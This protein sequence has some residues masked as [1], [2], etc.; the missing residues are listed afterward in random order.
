MIDLWSPT[1]QTTFLVLPSWFESMTISLGNSKR[2]TIT[3]KGGIRNS[4]FFVQSLKVNGKPWN[5]GWV[6]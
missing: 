4:A 1:G 6:T 5:K 2:L 3:T